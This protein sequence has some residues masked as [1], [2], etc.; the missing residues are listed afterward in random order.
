MRWQVNERD[1]FS[2]VRSRRCSGG[3]EHDVDA[4]LPAIGAQPRELG[5]GYFTGDH[6]RRKR[7][8]TTNRRCDKH[9]GWSSRSSGWS[10]S[11]SSGSNKFSLIGLRFGHGGPIGP[12]SAAAPGRSFRG[13]GYREGCSTSDSST[14][15]RFAKEFPDW[16]PPQPR[17]LYPCLSIAVTKK[18]RVFSTRIFGTAQPKGW[19]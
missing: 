12:H 9:W 1:K 4:L 19:S 14:F 2:H 11:G 5:R 13:C 18:T 6:R 16:K 8:R 17:F 7:R 10:G 15:L 3:G